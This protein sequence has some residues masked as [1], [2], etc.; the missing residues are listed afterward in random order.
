[1][2]GDPQAGCYGFSCRGFDTRDCFILRHP[3]SPLRGCCGFKRRCLR[4]GRLTGGGHCGL[5]GRLRDLMWRGINVRVV[6]WVRRS[7]EDT[8]PSD[9][10]IPPLAK[11]LLL[12]RWTGPLSFWSVRLGCGDD[13]SAALGR[14]LC[15]SRLRL[16]TLYTAT[17][18]RCVVFHAATTHRLLRRGRA[19]TGEVGTPTSDAPGCVSAVALRMA[20]LALQRTF[21]SQ[22]RP[23]RH[24]QT[25]EFGE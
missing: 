9:D 8:P 7:L 12:G 3:R 5:R 17:V 1:M 11:I 14:L 25:A 16:L 24:S 22:V 21:W 20:A 19:S 23:H 18:F 15:K 6:G 2:G 10:V 13:L 4:P